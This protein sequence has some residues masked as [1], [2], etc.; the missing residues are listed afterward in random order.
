[1]K[2]PYLLA[3]LVPLAA[4]CASLPPP[5]SPQAR[6]S[7]AVLGMRN[8]VL[9]QKIVNM[10]TTAL[11]KDKYF[12]VVE[13][14]AIDRV[15][16]EQRLQLSD[17]IDPQTAV[18]VGRLLGSQ[19]IVKSDVVDHKVTYMPVVVGVLVI[20]SATITSQVLDARTG[21]T[22]LA[23]SEVGRSYAGGA[24]VDVTS[25]GERRQDVLGMKRTEEDMFNSAIRDAVDKVAVSIIKA[26][27][28]ERSADEVMEVAARPNQAIEALTAR[29]SDTDYFW[30]VARTY[31]VSYDAVWT[32]AN[33]YLRGE[34][35]SLD[36]NRGIISSEKSSSEFRG[37]SVFL[38]ERVSDE[39]TKVTVK[40]FCYTRISTGWQ[41][42]S[43][44][45]C[46]DISLNGIRK[47][48]R[49]V[50]KEGIK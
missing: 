34:N 4:S 6:V 31:Y 9:D 23:V 21:R 37:R 1:M 47:N 49:E 22:L 30:A 28:G 45:F 40:V 42:S 14:H 3:I 29:H 26:V 10:L 35:V 44:G 41:K 48:I 8:G 25:G 27:Y 50:M 32:A 17:I 38:V 18:T 16:G 12:T 46:S 15:I 7:V 5:P 2:R 13:H 24:Q 19:V 43:P 11:S 20:R 39:A 33:R 36:R